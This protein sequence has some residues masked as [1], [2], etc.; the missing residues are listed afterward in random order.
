MPL[1]SVTYS[2]KLETG[3]EACLI[4]DKWA[5]T[6]L[7]NELSSGYDDPTKEEV[8]ANSLNYSYDWFKINSSLSA[9]YNLAR[10]MGT[11]RAHK[12]MTANEL[13]TFQ[14]GDKYG[15][16]ATLKL[17]YDTTKLYCFYVANTVDTG[18]NP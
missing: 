1:N 17:H 11:A 16:D 4:N 9:S 5:I 6:T 7:A 3:Q 18:D 2:P 13:N 15:H 10:A 8:L 14:M 12:T